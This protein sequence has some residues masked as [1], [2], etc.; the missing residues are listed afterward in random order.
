MKQANMK[1]ILLM[2]LLGIIACVQA[3]GQTGTVAGTVYDDDG[4]STLP[5]ANVYLKSNLSLGTVTEMDGSFVLSNV[6]VGIQVIV[7][8]FTGFE[9]AELTVDIVQGELTKIDA[10]LSPAAYAGAEIIVTAQALGQAKAINQQLNSDGIANFISS[11]KI[12][13]LPDVNAAEAIS[14]LP[15]VAINRSG[16][17]GSKVVVRGLDPKFTAISINGV[18]LP[19]TGGTDRSVDLSLISPELLSGI[20]LFKSPTPDMDGDALGGSINLNIL[21]APKERRISVK[22]LGGYNDIGGTFNDYKFTASLAQRVLNDKL[23]II[24]TV[25]VERFNRGGETTGQG[26]GDDQSVVLDTLLDIFKQNG[27]YLQFQKRAESRKRYN[28]SLGLDFE[29]GDKT[30]VT[31]LGIYSRTSRDQYNQSERYDVQNNTIVFTPRIIESAIDLYSGSISTRH[32]LNKLNV[33]WGAALSR[34][35][36]ETPY[37]FQLEFRDQ[38]S[39]FQQEVYS[40]RNQ[41]ANFFDYITS[42]GS[43]DYLQEARSISSGNSEDIVSAFVNFT[44]PILQKDNLSAT[45]KF[46]GKAISSTKERTYDESFEKNYYL[47][48]NT[49]FQ[50]FNS[51]GM[52][53]LGIDP[54]GS[55][56]YSMA[57]FTNQNQIDFLRQ[58]G[59]SATLLSSFNQ[60]LL[61]QFKT[62]FEDDLRPD[63]YGRV[64]NYDLTERVYA[65]YAMLKIKLGQTL[66]AIPGFRYEYSDNT[67]NGIYSDLSGDFG[68]SGALNDVTVDR[69]YGIFL[70]HL[71]LKFKPRDWVDFRAS[72]STT[73]ARPD[74]DYVVPFTV[75]NRSSDLVIT[76]GNPDLNASISTNYDFYAT[77]YSGKL[78]LFSVGLFYKDI[79]D[80]FYPFI[81]GLNNDSLAVAYGFAATGFGGAELTTY[82]NSPQ[83]NVRGIEFDLQSNLNFLPK[84]FDGLV[85]NINYTRLFSE[86]TVNSFYEETTFRGTFPFIFAVVEVFPFQRKVNLVGQARHILNASLGYDFKSFSMRVSTSYQGTKLSGY[87]S[88]SDKDTYNLG[89]WRFDAVLKQRF[90]N[91]FNIFLNLNNISGQED[92]NFFRS[93]DLVTSIARY[94]ATATIG[95]EYIFR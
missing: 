92:V 18:R 81:V 90:N 80:A 68:E 31:I 64:N 5:G 21:K 75:V 15:G 83:S 8:S 6:P 40:R 33:E 88:S 74:Y 87:S 54:T 65:T 73:L 66:T 41:P 17:E 19:S 84:P 42:D 44:M 62:T 51:E 50:P 85:L 71:H 82:T 58:N 63:R 55:F 49:Y 72:Y 53:A 59:E 70:P 16:G 86:T 57:N 26:W 23:G 20:E 34:V 39:P 14:R 1:S 52:G 7:V 43:K 28:G 95:A 94:G 9:A 13:E 3:V 76:E 78:G 36:G 37:D 56:Y 89:F 30:D 77:A 32:N 48:P 61:R 24:S 60:D 25:N 91:N 4:G 12:K 47:R 35:V 10:T 22:G 38:S 45:F 27:N 79:Q 46:G 93:E 69:N 67:Y 11:E 2:I 29:L